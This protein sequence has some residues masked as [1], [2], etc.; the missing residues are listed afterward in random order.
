MGRPSKIGQVVDHR[1]DGSPIT[2]GEKVVELTR[3]VWAPW[4]YVASQ[5]GISLVTLDNWRD[6]GGQARAKMARGEKVTAN[7]RAYAKFLGDLEKAE[8]EAVSARLSLIELAAKGGAIRTKTVT[9]TD[10]DGSVV[11]TETVETI[12]PEWTAAAWQ[13]ERRRPAEF[14]RRVEIIDEERANRL[15]KEER[16][17]RIAEAAQTYLDGVKDGKKQNADAP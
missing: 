13:L 1:E 11:V 5:A 12:A 3:T 2:A 7:Q 6:Q 14:G 9:K 10:P 8:A 15:S 4:R 16:L 17:D